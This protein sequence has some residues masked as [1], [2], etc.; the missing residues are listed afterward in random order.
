[1]YIKQPSPGKA[2]RNFS[3]GVAEEGLTEYIKDG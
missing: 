2:R 3:E 1:M